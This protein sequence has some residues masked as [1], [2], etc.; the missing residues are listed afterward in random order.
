MKS[1]Q[2]ITSISDDGDQRSSTD[3]DEADVRKIY[4]IYAIIIYILMYK[5]I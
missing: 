2:K 3:K 5:S 4:S 1:K